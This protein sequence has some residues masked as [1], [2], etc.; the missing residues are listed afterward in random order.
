M[1]LFRRIATLAYPLAPVVTRRAKVS[2]VAG[3]VGGGASPPRQLRLCGEGGA[4]RGWVSRATSHV[5]RGVR[6]ER[7]AGSSRMC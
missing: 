3:G 1:V 4:R 2:P 6:C 7:G 5:P